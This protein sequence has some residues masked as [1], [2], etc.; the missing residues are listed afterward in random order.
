ME[1]KSTYE[2]H[3]DRHSKWGID[4]IKFE[5]LQGVLAGND[6]PNETIDTNHLKVGAITTDMITISGDSNFAVGYDPSEKET[7][8]GAQAKATAAQIAAIAAAATDATTKVGALSSALGG[9]A[10]DDV[11]GAAK[12]D[13]TVIVGGYVKTTLLDAAYIKASIIDATYIN[14]L[15][16]EA[17]TVVA[18]VELTTPV[19][20]GGS[21][22]GSFF[23]TL[24][25]GSTGRHVE[26][27]D[28]GAGGYVV[29]CKDTAYSANDAY[30][31]GWTASGPVEHLTIYGPKIALSGNPSID[32]LNTTTDDTGEIQLDLHRQSR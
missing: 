8:T 3:G 21:I 2:R 31:A 9:L 14:S 30:I 7:P 27:E 29:F 23:S 4:P 22:Y 20:K 28:T 17:D 11:I 13:S 10:Y 19:I 32:F 24:E 12:L 6:I 1:R 16:I 25:Y 15:A 18:S 5:D 26:I